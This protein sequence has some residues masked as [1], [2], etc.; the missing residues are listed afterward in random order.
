MKKFLIILALA[1]TS[2]SQIAAQEKIDLRL[3]LVN[4]SGYNLGEA[5]RFVY[6]AA[7]SSEGKE[8]S[9]INLRTGEVEYK[10]RAIY[11]EG[12]F[13][14]FNPTT[15]DEFVVEIDGKRSVPF[16]I[17]DHYIQRISS[18]LAY[19]FFID[20][21][22]SED[23]VNS[24]EENVCGGGPSRDCGSY[25]LE[26]LFEVL[27]YS[28]NPALFDNWCGEL[29]DKK[30]AD[31]IDLILWHAEFA[32]HHKEF[33]QFVKARY[34]TLGY[35]GAPRMKYDYWNTLDHLAPVCAA[36]HSFLKPHMSQ[37][38]YQAYRKACL[39][40][41]EAYDRHKEVRYWVF[42]TK[43]V[44]YGFQEFNEMGNAFGQ[45]VF[46]NLFMYLCEKNEPDGQPD[47]FLKWAQ[48][49]AQDI[50]SN[51]DFNNPR[52]MWW[53]RNAEHITPQAL[54]FF[55]L[56]APEHAPQGTK[57]KLQQWA[58]H[59]KQR[60]N[61]P[62]RYRSHSEEEM[63]HD[64]TK[65]LGGAPALA[66]SM[67]AVSHLTDDAYLKQLGWAQVDFVFGANPCGAH[68]SHKSPE[69]VELGYW[70]GVEHGWIASLP[71]GAGMLGKVRG[72]L[73]GTPMNVHFKKFE[74][75][76]KDP[77]YSDNSTIKEEPYAT[78]GWAVSNRG[79]M[80][81]LTFS[82]L[83]S[84]QIRI[85]NSQGEPINS[86]RRGEQIRIELKAAL[87]QN[88]TAIDRGWIEVSLDQNAP[89]RIEVVETAPNSGLFEATY[90]IPKKS[91]K[92]SASY[93]YF[94]FEK[95]AELDIVR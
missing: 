73:D 54:A 58:I 88:Y 32:Y 9:I 74:Q 75:I 11:G 78:E 59:I 83:S 27:F 85:L 17:G 29:G 72:T 10:S 19:D 77:S 13:S 93:G 14:E 28:S 52:H 61:N 3:P 15:T 84:H 4:Q 33:N 79:W 2:L 30:R 56:V 67:F 66:G 57:E 69:R 37:E 45:G 35:P 42:S 76:I 95:R 22:G 65:E 31:L 63:A 8:F 55:L 43:W 87:N 48:E 18:K 1:A 62:W 71:N 51:W 34:G 21:R 80:A 60:T 46:R 36:Y 40:S 39:D 89:T 26:A 12:W 82:T 86:A 38:Q 94:G 70:E 41:W 64:R 81:S 50:I 49:C 16:V 47:K 68:I 6:P 90:T 23:P 7:S 92:L 5:K 44:D 25:G 20:V 53:V 24:N 91:K